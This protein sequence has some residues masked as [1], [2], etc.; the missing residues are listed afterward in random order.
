MAKRKKADNTGPMS[1]EEYQAF[2]A[3]V[4]R[5]KSP[6]EKQFIKLGWQLLEHKYRYY[7]LDQPIIQDHEY[8]QL[9]RE[10][11]RLAK[12]L[13]LPPTAADTVGFK[14]HTPVGFLVECKVEQLSDRLG[15]K[16]SSTD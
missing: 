14:R 2:I 9:E 10:Y 15:L 13:N 4:K 6:E 12:L 3:E 11:D 7:V 8:D 5:P 1:D 16:Q